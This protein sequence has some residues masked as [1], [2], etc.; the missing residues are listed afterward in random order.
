M[1]VC[2]YV[3]PFWALPL[4]IIGSLIIATVFYILV[5][6]GAIGLL[7]ADQLAESDA[8]LAHALDV[9]AGLSWAAAILALGAIVAITSVMLVIFYG[10]TRIFFA[11][12]R[13]GLLPE[14]LRPVERG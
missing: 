11:M 2:R 12:C 1:R 6:V 7:P 4:A 10:Q 13:D 8:P 5:S 14:R 9:G 3:R